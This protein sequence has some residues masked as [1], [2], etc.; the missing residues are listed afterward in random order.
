MEGEG[1]R[2]RQHEECSYPKIAI[3][4]FLK[5]NHFSLYVCEAGVVDRGQG[6]RLQGQERGRS[7][8]RSEFFGGSEGGAHIWKVEVM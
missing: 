1:D 3:V 5:T 7:G 8:L 6:R 2:T 4:F